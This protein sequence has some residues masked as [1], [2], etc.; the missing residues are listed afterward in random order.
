MAYFSR[1]T[2]IVTCNLTSLLAR[3]ENSAG[4][5]EEIIKEMR[6]GVTGA[7]RCVNTAT[8]NVARI[9]SEIDEQKATVADWFNQ[10]KDALQG[11]NESRARQALERKHE[12]EDLI[13]GLEQ[14]LQAAIATREHLS[15]MLCA[16]QA[17]LADAVRRL[18]EMQSGVK[19]VLAGS[20]PV[21]TTS[22]LHEGSNKSRVDSDLEALRS[23]LSG[24]Q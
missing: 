2:D 10:A 12:V 1:L 18:E 21:P 13:A 8:A 4:C 14:Q 20:K 24:G 11:N 17:R 7:Q 22:A 19:E 16:L 5:L 15:T 9:Q 23:A 3:N 6:E